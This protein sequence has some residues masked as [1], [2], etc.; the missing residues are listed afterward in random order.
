[1]KG[2]TK[3]HT[4][5]LACLTVS[6]MAVVWPLAWMSKWRAFPGGCRLPHFYCG[7]C[8]WVVL[9]VVERARVLCV[10]ALR[11]E[12]IGV[13]YASGYSVDLSIAL[14]ADSDSVVPHS[15]VQEAELLHPVPLWSFNAIELSNSFGEWHVWCSCFGT[16]FVVDLCVDIFVPKVGALLVV[17]SLHNLDRSLLAGNHLEESTASVE[18]TSYLPG[19]IRFGVQKSTV[20]AW[21]CIR[22]FVPTT[23]TEASN[24]NCCSQVSFG[25]FLGP[26]LGWC[27]SFPGSHLRVSLSVGAR[28]NDL[29]EQSK[30]GEKG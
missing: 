3:C 28:S 18:A 7:G 22:R 23:N 5:T 9:A 12:R 19:L 26:V 11:V 2:N 20:S 1:M 4:R 25:Q 6:M 15:G 21:K 29:V 14:R 27:Q 16:G 10:Y 8:T 30:A 24:H 13:L 17:E